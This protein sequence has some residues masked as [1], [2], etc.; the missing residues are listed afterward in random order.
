MKL[1]SVVGARPQFV[2]LAAIA[3][4]VAKTEHEHVI[5]HSGQHYD[6]RLSD[7]FFHELAV[8]KPDYHLGIGSGSHGA[9][10]GAMLA[11]MEAVLQEESPDWV[12]VYGDTNTTLA[13]ALA[14]VKLHLPVA[15]L[16]AGLRSFNRE[17]PEEHNRVLTDHAA[18]L[19]L[20][21]TILAMEQL[22]REG[23]G[24]RSVEVGDVMVDI[25][26][27]VRAGLQSN[28]PDLPPEL[29]EVDRYLVATVHRA[30]NTDERGRLHAVVAALA[31]LPLPV[32]LFAHPR[33]VE[34]ARAF[35]LR[36]NT[37][38]LRVLDP[39]PYRSMLAALAGA[40]GVIT[41]SGGVQKEAYILR[42]PC[43]TIRHQTEWPETLVGSWNVL[44]GDIETLAPLVARPRPDELP[45]TPFGDGTAAERVAEA[46]ESL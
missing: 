31:A 37:G 20:A 23:L 25:L 26:L 30:E 46:L 6:V 42:V 11:A 21:P 38:S 10:T 17:M 2:K 33:L 9:Q 39:L 35:S 15:H 32:M 45:V 29:L 5:V 4:A 19:L 27:R 36:L 43:T 44:A 22:E 34:R 12:I 41:D 18:D 3:A 16:E 8:P 1:L 14:S 40:V 7:V 13:A 24:P 28:P